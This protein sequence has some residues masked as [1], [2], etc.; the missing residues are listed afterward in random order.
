[1]GEAVDSIAKCYSCLILRCL[2]T[3]LEKF[4]ARRLSHDYPYRD[5][6]LKQFIFNKLV[7][8]S[9]SCG[10]FGINKGEAIAIVP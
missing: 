1:M 3:V 5:T 9:T 8:T 4:A 10:G 6:G 7:N 2:R